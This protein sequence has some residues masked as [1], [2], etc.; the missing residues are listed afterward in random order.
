V[1]SRVLLNQNRIDL[2]KLTTANLPVAKVNGVMPAGVAALA[3]TKRTNLRDSRSSVSIMRRLQRTALGASDHRGESWHVRG[4]RVAFLLDWADRLVS[5][6]ALPGASGAMRSLV[7][8]DRANEGGPHFSAL[9]RNWAC[10]ASVALLLRAGFSRIIARLDRRPKYASC[11]AAT[12]SLTFAGDA[13]KFVIVTQAAHSRT[14]DR[15]PGIARERVKEK[16]GTRT[17]PTDLSIW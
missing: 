11:A 4:A 3:L 9:N 8:Q 13:T 15:T 2:R 5:S 12:R 17:Y 1:S 10:S 16:P 6:P 7:S 14:R